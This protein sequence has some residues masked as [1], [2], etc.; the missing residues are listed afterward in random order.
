MWANSAEGGK[1]RHSVAQ[2]AGRNVDRR[3]SANQD[4]RR[5][6]QGYFLHNAMLPSRF[7]MGKLQGNQHYEANLDVRGLL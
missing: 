6:K 7:V 5:G 3:T 1:T 4:K 2:M